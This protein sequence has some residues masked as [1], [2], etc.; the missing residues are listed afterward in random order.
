M[1]R[2]KVTHVCMLCHSLLNIGYD[3][4]AHNWVSSRANDHLRFCENAED[5]E[6]AAEQRE[7]MLSGDKERGEQ[8]FSVLFASGAAAVGNRPPASS[9]SFVL[10]P[11]S[12]AIAGQARWYVYA[13]MRISKSAFEDVALHEMLKAQGLPRH[14]SLRAP[15]GRSQTRDCRPARPSASASAT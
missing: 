11:K 6:E 10:E 8:K 9:S 7:K 5:A 1:L 14:S 3:V 2:G 4:R 13:K 15:P 12:E